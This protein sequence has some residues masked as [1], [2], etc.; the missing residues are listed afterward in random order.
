MFNKL[1]GWHARTHT[2]MQSR[3]DGRV[4]NALTFVEWGGGINIITMWQSRSPRNSCSINTILAVRLYAPTF[5]N[6]VYCEGELQLL[7]SYTSCNIHR[8]LS[9]CLAFHLVYTVFP[10]QDRGSGE[11]CKLPRAPINSEQETA[12]LS[13]VMSKRFFLKLCRVFTNNQWGR[14]LSRLG[15]HLYNTL[16]LSSK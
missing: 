5:N 13:T 3:T 1:S 16:L 14:C 4:D 10:S 15:R 11:R 6:C 7:R 12:S 2:G 8:L 9:S